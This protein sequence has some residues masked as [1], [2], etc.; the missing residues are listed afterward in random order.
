M[1]C[2][3]PTLKNLVALLL[4]MS[5]ACHS[6]ITAVAYSTTSPT[7][8]SLPVAVVVGGVGEGGLFLLLLLLLLLALA[9]ALL[10]VPPVALA[11]KV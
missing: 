7:W 2:I 3:C 8:Q 9:L 11:V 5:F 1:G 6:P 10:L 4:S